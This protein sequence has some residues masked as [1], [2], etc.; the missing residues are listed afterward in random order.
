MKLIKHLKKINYRHYIAVGITLLFIT[1]SI[2]SY[3]DAF[4]RLIEAI[5]DFGISI[6]YYFCEL[7]H[8]PFEVDS[9]INQIPED[10]TT[11]IPDTWNGFKDSWSKYWT[12]WI[13]KDN[14]LSYIIWLGML[15]YKISYIILIGL[16]FVLLLYI[17]LAYY[18]RKQNNDYNKDS[19]P[20]KI[21]K[22]FNKTIYKNVKYWIL[23]SIDFLRQYKVYLYLWLVLGL[24]SFN[25]IAICFAFLGF[26][27]YFVASF[28]LGAIYTQIVKLFIDL[29]PLL[30]LPKIFWVCVGLY[31]F[32]KIAKNMAYARLN[33][34]ERMNRGFINERPIVMMIC[35]TMGKKKTTTLTD[36]TLSQE[37]MFRDTAFE[38]LLENDLKF[39]NFPWVNLENAIKR[40][41]KYHYIY[42]LATIRK[43]IDHLH[44]C[45]LEA[46]KEPMYY[47]SI[48][49]HLNKLYGLR[50]DNLLFDYDYE[51][52]GYTYNDKLKVVDI[53]E[54]ISTYAQLYFIYVCESSLIISNY[55]IRTDITIDDVGNFPMWNTELFRTDSRN[56]DY[57]S[58]YA[59]ILDFD[60]LR[61]GKKLVENS[62][63]A[64]SFE[65]GVV[66]ITEV[67]KERGNNLE[68]QEIKRNSETAN[69]K[70]DNMNGWLKMIRHSATVDNIPFVRVIT[71]EQR[72]ESWGADARDLC[73]IIHIRE[74]Y[75][76]KLA[77]SF[78][79]LYELLYQF[80][81][82]RFVNLYYKYRY[83]RAD[84]ILSMHILKLVV[85]KIHQHYKHIY[86]TFGYCKLR[87]QI[88]SGTQDGEIADKK[89]YLMSK[90][91]Y[92]K[93]FSTD[94][95]SD[96]FTEKALRSSYGINDLPS[97]KN[98]KAS[99]DELAEQN[100]YFVNSLLNNFKK[101]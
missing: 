87:I 85:S 100:S 76:T 96:F 51:T 27:F 20:L 64:D 77:L 31:I 5:K 98:V 41:M 62:E 95:F 30:S 34:Y 33:H 60:A 35:G 14:F 54:I 19:K 80:V 45:F 59:H 17:V 26:Y 22:W 83:V 4:I 74:T 101:K 67:G 88:E 16:P 71:D 46:I 24:Y 11:I 6:A 15:L 43:Y 48:K 18:L 58:R 97:Y 99:I 25:L 21:A 66:D 3:R 90:K 61:L 9:G 82:G 91:I 57:T 49:R 10:I 94:C 7:F 63:Y 84:N 70:N 52:Y 8:I 89:Y 23:A 47:K 36:I 75:E 79:F 55:S 37:I 53:W 78:F 86:N 13:D 2:L 29:K 1:I 65:F 93:R 44:C 39:P 56:I 92:S 68:L 69:Q 38:K 28:N 12:L 32:N 72:P 73:E 81:F 50:Y 42:N 40:G